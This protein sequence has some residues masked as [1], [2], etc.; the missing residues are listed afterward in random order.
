MCFHPDLKTFQKFR[1]MRPGC[2]ICSEACIDRVMEDYGRVKYVRMNGMTAWITRSHRKDFTPEEQTLIERDMQ[3]RIGTPLI[4]WQPQ[5]PLRQL[6]A[7]C[8]VL[9]TRV[10]KGMSKVAKIATSII[11]D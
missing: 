3:K 8:Y 11:K 2:P 7:Y 4:E 10:T 6:H 9:N 1:I 5:E